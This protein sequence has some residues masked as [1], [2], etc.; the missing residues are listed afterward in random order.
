LLGASRC[1]PASQERGTYTSVVEDK[2]LQFV[3]SEKTWLN[4]KQFCYDRGAAL[5]SAE[6]E[7]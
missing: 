1:P 6:T 3:F 5:A 7:R 2:C 4:A